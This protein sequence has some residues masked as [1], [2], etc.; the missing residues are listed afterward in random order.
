MWSP[1]TPSG[2]IE[3]IQNNFTAIR[4][5]SSKNEK[6]VKQKNT[7]QSKASHEQ[8]EEQIRNT[9]AYM[10][11]LIEGI[12]ACAVKIDAEEERCDRLHR[13]RMNQLRDKLEMFMDQYAEEKRT[14]RDLQQS[15][16]PEIIQELG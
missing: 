11:N 15:Q 12:V 2:E 16:R 8:I 10:D 4:S 6:N 3:K 5:G 14:L 13:A 9:R 1:K 7:M